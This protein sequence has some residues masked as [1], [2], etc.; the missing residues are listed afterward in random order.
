MKASGG[1]CSR[2]QRLRGVEGLSPC[3]SLPCSGKH[4]CLCPKELPVL[5]DRRVL[6]AEQAG[7]G[8]TP[9]CWQLCGEPE[10]QVCDVIHRS[11]ALP[12]LPLPARASVVNVGWAG[13]WAWLRAGHV[14]RLSHQNQGPFS[15]PSG[16]VFCPSSLPD[17][18]H[19]KIPPANPSWVPLLL[20]HPRGWSPRSVLS[21]E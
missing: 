12:R 7:G 19:G 16:N 15:S 6:A 10:A 17:S 21:R 8:R 2:D 9:C 20:R 11:Q 18:T 5:R 1:A 4:S 13:C 14:G 3:A